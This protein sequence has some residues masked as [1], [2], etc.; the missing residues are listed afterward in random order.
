MDLRGTLVVLLVGLAAYYFYSPETF[1]EELVRGKRVLVTGSSTGIGEQMAYEFAR[2]GAHLTVTARSEKR[3]QEVVRKCVELGAASARYVLADMNNLTAARQVV[4]ET[5][6]ELGG[7][8]YLVLNHVGGK[9]G[10]GP[11][12]GDMESVTSSMTV[13]FLSY[14][15]LT[16]AA[17]DM[18]RESEGAI[19]V[20][21]SAAGRLTSPFTVPYT[22]AKFALEG[23]YGSLRNELRLRNVPLDITVAVLGFINTDNA[24][25][26]V[27]EKFTHPAASKE[28]CARAVVRAGVLRHREVFFPY[29]T[30]KPIL[31][32]RDWAPELLEAMVAKAYRLE[33]IL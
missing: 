4:E 20:I 19:I 24:M 23:F 9:L 12:Q 33:N 11:F 29:W 32:L 30:T 6:R 15:Q 13:N 14:V 27:A 28:D 16:V 18:L 17:M 3:L 8:D 25:K 10:F 26:S 2:M 7:L 1:S 21:S 5:Q 22:A 31:L